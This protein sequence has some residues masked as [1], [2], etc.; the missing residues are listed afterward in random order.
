MSLQFFA[1]MTAAPSDFQK[2]E[3]L[4]AQT[5]PSSDP[6]AHILSTPLFMNKE[7]LSSLR[8]FQ[9]ERN[10]EVCFDSAGYYVQLG[11]IDY[12]ALYMKLLNC[13]RTHRWADRYVLPDNVPLS[14]DTDAQVEEKVHETVYYSCLLFKEMPDELKR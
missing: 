8:R 3:R 10:S 6:L 9:E 11:R 5:N 2:I 14:S 4:L 7:A 1:S 12:H 13:Y